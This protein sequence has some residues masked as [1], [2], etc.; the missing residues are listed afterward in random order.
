MKPN[1]DRAGA[2]KP[3]FQFISCRNNTPDHL[4]RALANIPA[5]KTV[6]RFNARADIALL[7]SMRSHTLT[8]TLRVTPTSPVGLAAAFCS[9]G[10]SGLNVRGVSGFSFSGC[11]CGEGHQAGH[12]DEEGL[13]L[14]VA[15]VIGVIDC[16]GHT[17]WDGIGPEITKIGEVKISIELWAI[18][19]HSVAARRFS[20]RLI[21]RSPSAFASSGCPKSTYPFTDSLELLTKGTCG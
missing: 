17:M 20:D 7:A 1:L 6:R 5:K 14:H 13:E 16:S 21:S 2:P 3:H 9:P 10:L 15:V 8:D 12:D 11:R 18:G 19:M 4:A